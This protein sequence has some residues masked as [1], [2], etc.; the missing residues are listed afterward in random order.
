MPTLSTRQSTCAVRLTPA[1][2]GAVATVLVTGPQAIEFTTA[3]FVPNS[4][5]TLEAEPWGTIRFGRW[6]GSRGEEVVVT[7]LGPT[8]VEVHCHGGVAAPQ[9]VLD[10]LTALGCK[11]ADWQTW[12]RASES[13]TI[14]SEA[15]SALAA[16][17]TERTAAV[18]LDQYQGALERAGD[19]IAE[20]LVENNLTAARSIVVELLGRAA[21]GLHLTV[22][23]TV[24]LAGAPNVGKSSLINALVGYDRTIVHDTPG[25]TRDVV[26]APASLA[27]WPVELADTAGLRVT[28]DP[29]EAAGVELAEARLAA[30]DAI[31]LVFD[32]RQPWDEHAARLFGRWSGAIVVYNKSDLATLPKD[33]RPAGI[34]TSATDGCG[35][36]E[37]ELAIVGQLV[38]AQPA[39]GMPV[40]F[41]TRQV[42]CLQHALEAIARSDV[43]A[44]LDLLRQLVGSADC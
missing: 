12:L 6:G 31:V 13:C 8:Q 27:G 26:T 9:A 2:R 21:I 22:P 15:V 36:V 16:A 43:A 33:G 1:G 30:A 28:A 5:R 20:R 39:P 10:S 42:E 19:E 14:R 34:L 17:Q 38:P 18:L 41:S 11:L 24:V 44:A 29:L 32:I 7:A 23:R 3:L 25:T 35:L 37:L 40:P 4:G